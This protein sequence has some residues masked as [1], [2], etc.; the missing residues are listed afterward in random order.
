METDT[1]NHTDQVEYALSEIDHA[2]YVNISQPPPEESS[3]ADVRI[4]ISD[5]VGNS[6]INNGMMAQIHRAGYVCHTISFDRGI[7]DLRYVGE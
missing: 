1:I 2:Q 6:I 3:E 5:Y 7:V 4:T